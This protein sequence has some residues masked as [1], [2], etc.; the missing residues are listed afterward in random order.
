MRMFVTLVVHLF[1]M[2][3]FSGEKRETCTR[4]TGAHVL[5]TAVRPPGIRPYHHT[6]SVMRSRSSVAGV[7]ERVEG[8]LSSC[9]KYFIIHL[10]SGSYRVRVTVQS[11]RKSA[12]L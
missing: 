3:V 12:S 11:P 2:T 5:Q 10:T 1:R 4:P 7:S 6:L 9:T 8:V